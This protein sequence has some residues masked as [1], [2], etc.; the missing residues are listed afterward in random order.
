VV[1]Q[2]FTREGA[3]TLAADTELA[4]GGGSASNEFTWIAPD[5]TPWY[6][7]RG[8]FDNVSV[9]DSVV[10]SFD[11]GASSSGLLGLLTSEAQSKAARNGMVQTALDPVLQQLDSTVLQPLF[12]ALGLTLGGADARIR[13]VRCQVPALANRDS[14]TS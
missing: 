6:R 12:N 10:G 5:P 14:S 7:Y 4:A 11:F 13:E 9:T 3:G 1:G 8:G 2:N